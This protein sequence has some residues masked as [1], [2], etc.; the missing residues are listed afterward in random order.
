MTS[1]QIK[2]LDANYIAQTYAKFDLALSHGQGCEVWD[3][4]GNKYL[5][6]TSGIGV[7]SLGWAD[8]D[9]LE[10]VI[11]QLH[12]LSHT[13]NLFYTEPSARLAKHLVQVSGL[14]RVFFA[15]SGAEANEGAIKVARKYSHDKY[16]DTRSTIISLVNSFHGRTISTLAATGQKLFHQHFFPFTAGFEHLIAN[17]LNAFKTRIA[18]NDICAIILEVVQGEGGVC[19]LDQAYLQAVQ[20]LCQVQDILLIIDEVQTGIGR[21]GTMFAY[22]QFE[23]KPDIVTLAKGLAGGLPIGAFLLADKVAENLAKGDHGSTFGAN[24]VSC[25]AANAVLTKLEP[26]FLTEVM[27]KGQK[28]RKALQSLPHVKSISGLG[29]MIGVEFDEH[30]NVADVVTNCLKQGVLFLTA[31]TKLRMLPPLIIN[32]EQLE[33]GVTVLAQVLS[34]M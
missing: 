30:I 29:L 5:D 23:L 17:D 31:K 6:F 18:Q 7:N 13:S 25:A 9:W 16:G 8:P 24:P 28:L 15:N 12:K 33:R 11:A 1:D 3:F 20:G 22:Q 34:E 27:R 2:Q 26:L 32:D 10:A 21:T 19:S 4:D 14:K